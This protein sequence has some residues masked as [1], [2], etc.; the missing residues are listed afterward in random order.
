MWIDPKTGDVVRTHS[1]VRLLRPNW[2]GP[3]I[4]TD[5]MV[6]AL[7]FL[8][9]A[10]VIPAYDPIYQSATEIAPA[11]VGGIW[12]QQWVVSNYPAD[13]AN[14]NLAALTLSL[15]DAIDAA[16]AAAAEPPQR[17]TTEYLRREAQARAYVN[18]CDA[19]PKGSALPAAPSLIANFAA[20]AQLTQYAAARLTIAQ[21]DDLYSKVDQLANLRMRKYEVART[22]KAADKQSLFNQIMAQIAAV[23]ATIT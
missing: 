6:L 19:L 13:V 20:S 4:I 17:F 2:S 15:T 12:T 22:A 21:A 16:V 9:V 10:P 1:D 11:L 3:S 18:D 23:A 5:D 8:L 14:Q 7:G